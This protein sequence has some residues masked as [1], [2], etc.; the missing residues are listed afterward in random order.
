MTIAISLSKT[1]KHAGKYTAIVDAI[2]SDLDLL[3]WTVQI[4]STRQYAIRRHAIKL[5]RIILSRKLGR[6]LV[7]GEEVD[8][9]NGNGLDNRREN[10]RLATRSQNSANRGKSR[11]NTSGHKGVH[12]H[13]KNQCWIAQI[14]INGIKKY[15]GSFNTREDAYQV[16]CEASDKYHQEYA[17]YGDKNE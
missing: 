8:H 11:S 13:T 10:L 3:S 17:N 9:I 2:D 6:E 12:W 16:Y 14:A 4:F 5:H 15:L 7:K 1:G